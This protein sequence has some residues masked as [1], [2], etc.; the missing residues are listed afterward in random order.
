MK[1]IYFYFKIGKMASLFNKKL[2]LPIARWPSLSRLLLMTNHA[3]RGWLVNSKCA[4]G[5]VQGC[6]VCRGGE[7]DLANLV[8]ALKILKIST[9]ENKIN[10]HNAE[11]IKTL[12]KSHKQL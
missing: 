7:E 4:G 8:S 1:G 2:V 9:G 10:K 12:V 6:R 5:P 3:K 11:V